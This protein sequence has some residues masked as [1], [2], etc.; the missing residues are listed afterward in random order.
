MG[1]ILIVLALAGLAWRAWMA[2]FADE[3]PPEAVPAGSVRQPSLKDMLARLDAARLGAEAAASAAAA[4]KPALAADEIEVCGV[5]RV[6]ADELGQPR[7]TA[8]LQLAAQSARE[9]LLPALLGSSDENARA[10]GLLLQ[11]VEVHGL[12]DAASSSQVLARDMLASM[13]L[14]TR[15]PQV[16]AWAMRACQNGRG[17]GM[18][19]L[20]SADQWARLEPGN[21]VAW[22]QVAV[23]AQARNEAAAVAEAMF[24]AS[25]ASR[26]D[27][28]WGAFA[29]QVLGRLPA[30]TPVLLKG[31]LA[32]ELTAA[33]AAVASPHLIASQYCS[34]AEVRDANRRQTCSAVAEVFHTR[35]SSLTDVGLA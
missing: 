7:D 4:A 15:S 8:T 1:V 21:A 20:L 12:G 13:A 29:G 33:E 2:G 14:A 26:A 3:P 27:T 35:G 30:E 23:D 17:E 10:A 9:R 32:E 24:R 11:S 5:G 28:H 19:Q 25:H 6:K 34:E 31:A 18:C 22:L 16:Y